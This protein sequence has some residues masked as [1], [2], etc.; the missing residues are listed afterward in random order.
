MIT[1]GWKAVCTRCAQNWATRRI[2]GAHSTE[3]TDG[4]PDHTTLDG[5]HTTNRTV[6]G[7]LKPPFHASGVRV[8]TPPRAH[9]AGISRSGWP[10]SGRESANRAHFVHNARRRGSVS[11]WPEAVC[12]AR[13]TAGPSA[14]MPECTLTPVSAASAVAKALRPS[15]PRR[16]RLPRRSP[17]SAV[18]WR[19][20]FVCHRRRVP[21][22]VD[23]NRPTLA[24]PDDRTRL[25]AVDRPP[26][27]P[28]R[29]GAAPSVDA[30]AGA[31]VLRRVAGIGR[32]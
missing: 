5:R 17:R 30:D 15:G 23:R 11:Q 29:P 24:A 19:F 22:G 7:G 20:P 31:A 4:R 18:A 12:T 28:D 25:R 21:G 27:R 6:G 26:H 10:T 8:R 16:R 13:T 9:L 1:G 2:T 3:C 14:S 32:S